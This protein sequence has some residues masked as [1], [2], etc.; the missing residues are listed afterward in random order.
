MEMEMHYKWM[1]S[2][3]QAQFT[4]FLPGK[5]NLGYQ[6]NCVCTDEKGY[7]IAESCKAEFWFV[8]QK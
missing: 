7:W 1:N 6:K 5:S 3:K 8:C 4:A 2:N